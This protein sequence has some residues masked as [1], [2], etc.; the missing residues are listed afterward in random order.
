MINSVSFNVCQHELRLKL[1][2]NSLW[3]LF[4]LMQLLLAVALWTSWQQYQHSQQL[5]H[6]S[7]AMVE[8][9]WNAQ[10]DRH[11][12]RVA[13]F[14]HF[15]FRPPSAL[16]YFDV[17]VNS[18]VGHSVFLE[19]HKQNSAN[20]ASDSHGSTLLRFSE[21]SVA[22]LL[23]LVW[24]LLLIVM[25]FSSISGERQAGTLKQLISIGVQF[26]HILI[27][28]GFAYWLLSM[29]FLVPV[30]VATILVALAG[31]T[32][33]TS[34][35]LTRI[36]L[37]FMSYALY[38]LFWV[39]LILVCSC[40]TSAPKQ[41]LNVLITI[42]F[43]LTILTPRAVAD[44]AE[45]L[46]PHKNANDLALAVK[47][48]VRKVGNSHNPDDPH[49]NSF[50][51]SVLA[52]YG[53]SDVADLPINYRGLVMQEGERITAEIYQRHADTQLAQFAAQQAFVARFYWLNPYLAI[54][55]F[56]M[57][58]SASDQRHF[59]DFERQ[60][61][62]HRYERTQQLNKL[63]TEEVHFHNDRDQRVSASFWQQFSAFEYTNP[64]L[65]W[66]LQGLW[67]AVLA[68]LLS[69]IVLIFVLARGPLQRKAVVYA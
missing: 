14:G 48:D 6:T 63:H 1:K 12:H 31:D 11:P 20:F 58:V 21:L 33:F 7:Q 53:V 25:A 60:A 38:C 32:A 19:A 41:S 49:F 54:R 35:V 24:P 39:V 66:S 4:A 51:Q 44:I 42:W 9:Q 47:L 56:S 29:G 30:F 55:D 23:L 37:L 18:W 52:Q 64:T 50:K 69:L 59:F 65:G 34:D 22:N 57:A 13:H 5:Q 68:P 61:E 8:E 36:A 43:V 16:S 45:H 46:Y 27:G 10:P 62:Q 40:L 17:G 28:K 2:N 67:L 15:A 3:L 26:K